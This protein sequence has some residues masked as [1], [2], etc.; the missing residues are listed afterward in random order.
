MPLKRLL[1]IL[2]GR[3]F[4]SRLQR[5]YRINEGLY[6]LAMPEGEGE[7]NEQAL[8]HLDD[9][10]AHRSA[11]G[12]LVLTQWDRVAEKARGLKGVVDVVHCSPEKMDSLFS[13]YE[14]YMFSERLLIASFDKPYGNKL[15]KA[16]GVNGISVEDLV[17][18]GVLGIRT[19]PE[20]ARDE[21]TRRDAQ[22]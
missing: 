2:S 18:L 22:S 15:W 20:T 13:Y 4:W 19:W 9:L 21:R 5:R 6:V 12:V 8:A 17:C 14:L 3:R 1:A 7:V 16:L 11:R 10:I